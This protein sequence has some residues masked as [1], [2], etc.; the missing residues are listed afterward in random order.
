MSVVRTLLFLFAATALAQNAA[1]D[2]ASVK[3]N[4]QFSMDNRGTW[5]SSIDTNPGT[6]T[7][8]NV[9]LTMIVAWAYDVQRPQISGPAWINSQRYD[10]VAK[11]AGPAPERELRRMLQTLL[12]ERFKLETHRESRQ[13]DVYAI[14]L[15]K[16]GHK[17]TPS[18][19]EESHARQDPARGNIVE[20][21]AV[22]E[23]AT[24]MSRETEVPIVDMTGLS[25][26]FDF[27]FNVQKY[28]AAL[29]DRVQT[30]RRP[31][32][33]NEAN[34][35]IM[36]DALAGELGLKLEPRKTAVD[37]IVI[38]KAEKAPVQN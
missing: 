8:R 32:G 25:G 4:Q 3:I 9:N 19:A 27:T 28:V 38:D 36:Q 22:S 23:L 35:L 34:L 17:M 7:M 31:I 21:A 33:D 1:F 10:I 5:R 30:E 37:V 2:V 13:M 15:P 26:R 20:G 6:L 16:S 14:L 12:T 11:A 18:K 29:R 24:E